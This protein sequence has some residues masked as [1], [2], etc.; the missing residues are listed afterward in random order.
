MRSR[1]M[2]ARTQSSVLFRPSGHFCT[3]PA[4]AIVS[5]F[6]HWDINDINAIYRNIYLCRHKSYMMPSPLLLSHCHQ[7]NWF[8]AATMGFLQESSRFMFS[9]Q[10]ITSRSVAKGTPVHRKHCIICH[11]FLLPLLGAITFSELR[12]TDFHYHLR[13]HLYNSHILPLHPKSSSENHE[14]SVSGFGV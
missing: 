14:V 3:L 7:R 8:I 10:L 11:A 4:F 1:Q 9:Y 13:S 5:S 12:I 6:A 2:L